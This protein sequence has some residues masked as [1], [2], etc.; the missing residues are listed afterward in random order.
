MVIRDL[1]FTGGVTSFA[2]RFGSSFPK[3]QGN[4]GVTRRLVPVPMVALVATAVS[5]VYYFHDALLI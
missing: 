4:D 5:A 3:A 1:Y 2:H